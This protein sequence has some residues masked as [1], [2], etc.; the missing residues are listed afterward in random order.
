[1]VSLTRL[2]TEADGGVPVDLGPITGLLQLIRDEH[3]PTAIWLFGSRAR[4]PAVA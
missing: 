2:P 4:D 1:M 3:S